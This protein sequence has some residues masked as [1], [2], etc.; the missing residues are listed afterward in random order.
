MLGQINKRKCVSGNINKSKCVSGNESENF[1]YCRLSY[2][3][4]DF[5][6]HNDSERHFVFQNA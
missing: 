2:F 4:L 5:F 6:K 1:K 3:F